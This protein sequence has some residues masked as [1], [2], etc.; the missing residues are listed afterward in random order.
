MVASTVQ[1]I[2]ALSNCN[3]PNITQLVSRCNT[4]NADS[5]L[6][7]SRLATCDPPQPELGIYSA[8]R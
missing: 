1:T 8:W 5:E 4:H 2:A 6:A 7:L 3:S